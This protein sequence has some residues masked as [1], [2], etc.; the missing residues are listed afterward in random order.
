MLN[1]LLTGIATL[2]IINEVDSY[3]VEDSEVRALA[4]SSR[5]G[6]N[7][8]NTAVVLQQLNIQ[9]SLLSNMSDDS[10]A[11]FIIQQL[12]ARKVDTSPCPVQ[13]NSSTPTSYITLSRETGS[14]SI[15]HYRQLDELSATDFTRLKLEKFDWFHFEA[16]NCDQLKLMLRHAK[17]TGKPISLELEKPRPGLDSTLDYAD[18]LLLSKPFAIS[19]GFDSAEDCLAHFAQHYADKTISCTWGDQ[20][21]WVCHQQEIHHCDPHYIE[22][23][24]ETLGAGDTYNAGFIAMLAKQHP[25]QEALTFA[26]SLAAKKC[27]QSGFD[28]LTTF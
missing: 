25:A 19:R 13:R 9:A 11:H 3:P 23:P 7:A 27:N 17:Q 16:R 14:R 10:N 8:A 28:Q 18:V 22:Q 1:I 24:V 2:D 21:A 26:C 4:Q 6:G 12:Q 20:G 15:V 5:S